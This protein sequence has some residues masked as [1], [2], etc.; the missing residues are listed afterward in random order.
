MHPNHLIKFTKS[1]LKQLALYAYKDLHIQQAYMMVLARMWQQWG[2]PVLKRG[3]SLIYSGKSVNFDQSFSWRNLKPLNLKSYM[4]PNQ[5]TSKFL[6]FP[7]Q[8]KSCTQQSLRYTQTSPKGQINSISQ[9]N[10][11]VTMT[12]TSLSLDQFHFS[13]KLI[14]TPPHLTHTNIT[15]KHFQFLSFFFFFYLFFSL[16]ML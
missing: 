16:L 11:L 2:S 7:I 4:F 1:N 14:T 12:K 5:V 15:Y 9:T 3:M 6:T 13:N 10:S 8:N